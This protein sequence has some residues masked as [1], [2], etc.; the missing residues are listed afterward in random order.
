MILEFIT[1]IG[2][3]REFKINSET[4]YYCFYQYSHEKPFCL[5]KSKGKTRSGSTGDMPQMSKNTRKM[6]AEF[7]KDYTRDFMEHYNLQFNW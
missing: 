5:S 4:G 6:L 2:L 3:C 7:Y 1:I